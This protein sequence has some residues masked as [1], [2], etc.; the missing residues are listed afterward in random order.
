MATGETYHVFNRSVGK[1]EIFVGARNLR[2]VLNLCDYYRFPQ[3]LRFSKFR[4][5]KKEIKD[6]YI[7]SYKRLVPLVEIYAFAFMPTHYHFLLKQMV[8]Q[9][10]RQFI[11]NFQNSFAKAFNLVNDRNG[12]L[13]QTPFKAKRIETDEEFMHVSRYIHLNP[14]TSYLI[15]LQDLPHYSWTSFVDYGMKDSLFVNTKFL[16][17]MFGSINAYKKFVEDQSDYQK[18]LDVIKHLIIEK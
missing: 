6:S 7:Q 17:N 1:T 12:T 11:S 8:D 5:L 13:F 10:I 9:G 18:R 15:N 4:V 2:R 16:L 3:K 14:V